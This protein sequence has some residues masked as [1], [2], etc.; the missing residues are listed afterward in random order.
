M[1]KNTG[2][3]IVV[4]VILSLLVGFA[5]G[6]VLMGEDVETIK[7]V[8]VTK[9]VN[10]TV[11]KLVEVELPAPD[12]LSL[13]VDAFM[14]AVEDEEDE[15]GNAVDVVGTYDFDE[16]EVSRVYDDYTVS[17]NDEVTTVDFS[18][19]LRFDEDGEASE[20]ETYDVT[21][22]FEED[23]DTEVEVA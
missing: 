4:F 18:I 23:E 21:V 2:G 11:E 5:L 6:A 8:E 22:I 14:Q 1:E 16:I 19:K 9:I 7:E 15:A 10:V 17:Y 13:A 3:I 20:K 12:M